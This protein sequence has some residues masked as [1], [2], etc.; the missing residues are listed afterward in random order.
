MDN[1]RTV[2]MTELEEMRDFVMWSSQDDMDDYLQDLLVF[3]YPTPESQ[4]G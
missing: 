2:T 4:N 1:P 3:S